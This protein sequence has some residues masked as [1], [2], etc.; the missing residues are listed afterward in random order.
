MWV[1]LLSSK[2]EVVAAI[3]NFQAAIEVATGRKLKTLQTDHGGGSS[4]RWNSV[5]TALN[6][7]SSVNSLLRTPRN[8]MELLISA[9]NASSTWH[10]A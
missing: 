9:T 4:P 5:A 8:K 10:G 1:Q 3:K 7:A 2:D 6:T